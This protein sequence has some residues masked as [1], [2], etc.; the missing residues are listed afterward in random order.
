MISWLPFHIL[1]VTWPTWS[2]LMVREETGKRNTDI[3]THIDTHRHTQQTI[4]FAFD[5]IWCLNRATR[6]GIRY[7]FLLLLNSIW[8]A[9]IHCNLITLL[10][11]SRR[12]YNEDFHFLKVSI[13]V[14]LSKQTNR[15]LFYFTCIQQ[16]VDSKYLLAAR[17][18]AALIGLCLDTPTTFV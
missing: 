2:V 4:L 9:N 7:I 16:N 14:R 12:Y 17:Q 18:T 6:I 15:I 8:L 1:V 5:L 11:W 10:I 3:Q 13:G